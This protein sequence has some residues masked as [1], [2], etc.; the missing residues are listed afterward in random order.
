MRKAIQNSLHRCAPLPSFFPGY[1]TEMAYFPVL[2]VAVAL[3]IN[4]SVGR[5]LGRSPFSVVV[6]LA[7]VAGAGGSP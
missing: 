5:A 2:D 7:Q 4:T 1:L 6:E 3:Q